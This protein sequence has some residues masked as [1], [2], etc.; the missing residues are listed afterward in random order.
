MGVAGL[1]EGGKEEGGLR[2]AVKREKR[3]GQ[4][5]E[6]GVRTGYCKR[7]RKGGGF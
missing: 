5:E 3:I 7:G 2:G 4:S 1:R 6:K